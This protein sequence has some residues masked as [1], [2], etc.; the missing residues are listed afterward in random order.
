MS[1]ELTTRLPP[2]SYAAFRY[3]PAAPKAVPVHGRVMLYDDVVLPPLQEVEIHVRIPHSHWHIDDYE[4][5]ARQYYKGTEVG[6][7][8]W[9][10]EKRLG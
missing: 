10:F 9:L 6:R 7:V 1:V 4:V 8:T 2:G 3:P 5:S